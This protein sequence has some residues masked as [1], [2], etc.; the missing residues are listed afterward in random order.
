MSQLIR[1]CQVVS[2]VF[3][4]A[5]VQGLR[6]EIQAFIGQ[7][8]EPITALETHLMRLTL[9]EI[10]VRGGGTAHHTYHEAFPGTCRF[11]PADLLDR[12][13]SASPVDPRAT[14]TQWADDYVASFERTH[15]PLGARVVRALEAHSLARLDVKALAFEVGCS[16]AELRLAFHS[17]TGIA[18]QRYHS[19]LRARVALE[20]LI[21]SDLKIDALAEDLGYKSKKNMYRTLRAA[22]GLTP[23]QM[24]HLGPR[25][26]DD[27]VARLGGRA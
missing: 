2:G 1:E 3:V 7:L 16:P 8:P 22:F 15:V 19:A 18:L 11:D 10:S 13:W 25:E 14:F 9:L 23:K 12:Y 26:V 27:L 24:R 4:T 17:W 6:S 21:A 20:G 5:E